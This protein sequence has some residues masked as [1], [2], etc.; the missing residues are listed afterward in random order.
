M[1]HF[2]RTNL[3]ILR[4]EID[5]ALASVAKNHGIKINA[6]NATFSGATVTFKL[7]LTAADSDGGF[8]S[9]EAVAFTNCARMFGL[10]ADDLGKEFTVAGT[11]YKVIGLKTDAAK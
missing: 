8:V 4:A 6:G 3:K 7:E 1:K 5:A 9:K 11:V 10:E 2:D